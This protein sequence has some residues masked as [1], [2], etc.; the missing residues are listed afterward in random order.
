MN[1]ERTFLELSTIRRNRGISLEQIAKSTKISIRSLEA[2]ERGDFR[3]LPG[4]IY[5]TSYIR[6]YA[7]AIDYDEAL[8]LAA[9]QRQMGPGE[10]EAASPKGSKGFFSGLRTAL[11]SLGARSLGEPG[12]AEPRSGLF[13][14]ETCG[15][16]C[17]I[18]DRALV[19]ALSDLLF[20]APRLDREL[21]P[22]VVHRQ[23]LRP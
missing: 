1:E 11:S 18:D 8:L 14:S 6:Q 23:H 2:I 19:R 5:N 20:L 12:P 17:D 9:Y 21:N 7:K 10:P 22:P 16:P 15:E 4:G 13:C 3:K